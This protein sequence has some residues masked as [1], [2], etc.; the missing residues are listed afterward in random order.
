MGLAPLL[1][2]CDDMGNEDNPV[3]PSTPETPET[4]SEE[5]AEVVKISGIQIT[6]AGITPGAILRVEEGAT[7]QLEAT[8]TPA[9]T[10]ETDVIWSSSDEEVATVSA[11]GLVT[12]VKVGEAKIAVT[13]KAN[14]EISDTLLVNVVE[15][16]EVVPVEGIVLWNGYPGSG[17]FA[18][19][20]YSMS[21]GNYLY[22]YCDFSPYNTTQR[23][24]EWKISDPIVANI[25]EDWGNIDKEVVDVINHDG[26]GIWIRA[27]AEG[28][29]TLTCVSSSNKEV[30]AVLR[31]HIEKQVIYPTWI[32]ISGPDVYETGIALQPGAKTQLTGTVYPLD[33]SN[34]EFSWSSSDESVATVSASGE[35][36]AIKKGMAEITATA[37]A[38]GI[39]STI[40]VSV[41]E[42]IVDIDSD[43]VAPGKAES[44]R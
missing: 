18:N 6:G 36:T 31:I 23:S 13:S 39:T 19:D 20:E 33:A 16:V 29:V 22:V 30:R 2:S 5:P 27:L 24:V 4:P 9:D 28:P 11:E 38:N 25:I 42:G 32:E 15:P 17:T 12:G 41:M 34:R 8:L 7:R 3:A 26:Y 1:T 37:A 21:I 40:Q 35:V 43:A 14:E 10:D 44:R